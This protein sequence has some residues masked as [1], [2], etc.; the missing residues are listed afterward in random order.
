[1]ELT[2]LFLTL[3]SHR[4]HGRLRVSHDQH[5]T[6]GLAWLTTL[7]DCTCTTSTARAASTPL[8]RPSPRR[9]RATP[10]RSP[11]TSRAVRTH[12]RIP[13]QRP[14]RECCLL[15]L[16]HSSETRSTST[17]HTT[18]QTGQTAT[19]QRTV[20]QKRTGG[21]R[22]TRKRSSCTESYF[23][24]ATWSKSSLP[25]TRSLHVAALVSC[26]TDPG[27]AR[28]RVGLV[29][30]V[31]D[32]DVQTTFALDSD[33]VPLCPRHVADDAQSP[34]TPEEHLHGSVQRVCR[35]EPARRARHA[36]SGQRDRQRQVPERGR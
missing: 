28:Q 12:A 15:P 27:R 16:P 6:A 33:P 25:G 24:Y 19:A 8:P 20:D 36:D 14:C 35:E 21:S 26:W 5:R 2:Q 23:R 1:M 7:A 18:R 9:A 31:L 17:T 3:R 34:T 11:R 13:A 30:L 22:S 10:R 4:R 29:S 32:F